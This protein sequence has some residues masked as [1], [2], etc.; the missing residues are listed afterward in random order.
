[1][2]AGERKSYQGYEVCL[3]PLDYLYCTQISEPGSYSH[4]CGTA[5]DWIGTSSTYPYYAPFSCTR[6]YQ[7]SDTVCYKNDAPVWTPSGLKQDVIIS[8]T[9]DNNPPASSHYDQGDLI[10][11]TG[12]A[13]QVTGDHVHL[14][15]A[16][17]SQRVLINSGITCAM[18]NRCWY[19]RNGILPPE[20][21]YLSGSE[22]VV[23][24]LGQSFHT[25]SGGGGTGISI[26]VLVLLLKKMKERRNNYGKRVTCSL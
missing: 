10:G 22:T 1:M 15:Q 7:D 24:T 2:Q 21:Y 9:H 12:T 6:I 25:W 26:G 23:Q 8:F 13:G 3:F 14:D 18:G 17:D 16:F 19:I 20:C 4:C 11:H 5:T